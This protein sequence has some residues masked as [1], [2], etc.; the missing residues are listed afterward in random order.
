VTSRI[1]ALVK[2]SVVI[3]PISN[4]S[5]YQKKKGQ[6]LVY[7]IVRLKM[8]ILWTESTRVEGNSFDISAME[9]VMSLCS[10]V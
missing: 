3:K 10:Y 5:Y 6:Q 1:Y 4:A 8:L 7:D 9:M 2:S